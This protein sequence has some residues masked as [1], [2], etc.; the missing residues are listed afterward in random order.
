M[1]VSNGSLTRSADRSLQ[2]R[3]VCNAWRPTSSAPAGAVAAVSR[4]AAIRAA[5]AAEEVEAVK[6]G[7]PSHHRHPWV[8]DCKSSSQWARRGWEQR[9]ALETEIQAIQGHSAK[10]AG[11]AEAALFAQ[12]EGRAVSEA[13]SRRR[14]S[15]TPAVP[16]ATAA[17]S[18]VEQ[19]ALQAAA[20][21]EP[22]QPRWAVTPAVRPE[23]QG[24][25]VRCRHR[26]FFLKRLVSEGAEAAEAAP[27]LRPEGLAA[28]A[29]EQ[30]EAQGVMVRA[31]PPARMLPPI[32]AEEAGEAA[33]AA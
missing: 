10:S 19:Q 1:C 2:S 32:R 25:V 17:T 21:E 31:G 9:M 16:V 5:V 33:A 27:R 11:Q 3:Q 8:Q 6:L 4:L 18:W 15:P 23:A 7:W 29:A 12:M 24:V 14:L 30:V 13:Q 20:E 22:A 28:A 26:L